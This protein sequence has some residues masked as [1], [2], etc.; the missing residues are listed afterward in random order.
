[1]SNKDIIEYWKNS[2]HRLNLTAEERAKLPE[3]P[4]GLVELTDEALDDLIS[5]GVA[6]DV[7]VS[8]CG[9]DS[10]N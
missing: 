4:A 3:N 5:G 9:W 7:E 10:C 8:S 6:E 1:M 2:E